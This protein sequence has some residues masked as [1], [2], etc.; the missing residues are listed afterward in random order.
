MT[1]P[2]QLHVVFGAGPLGQSVVRALLARGRQV[3]LVNRSGAAPVPATVDIVAGDAYDPR[4]TRAVTQGAAVVYQCAQPLYQEWVQRFPLLQEAI[5]QGAAHSGAKMVI[6]DN[7]YMYG[8][9]DGPIHEGLPYAA[10]TRKGAVRARMAESAFQMHARGD[11]KVAVGRG[12]DF[13]GPGVRSSAAGEM[14]FANILAGKAAQGFGNIDQPH[15][16]TFIEDFGEALAILG[17][18]ES[19]F[20]Q[21]WHIPNAETLTTRQF[22]TLAFEL[23]ARPPKINYMGRV[24]LAIGGLF[25]PAAREMIEMVYEFE[26]PFVVDSRKFVEAFGDCSTPLRPALQKTLDWFQQNPA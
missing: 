16:Y 1:E 22:F 5:L 23:A 19:A 18:H 2:A 14:V 15:T 17:E 25:I 10:A 24:M 6:G 11:L 8:E 13:Y 12:S 9:V 3:R 21:V 20:G 26:K 4:F 7:L